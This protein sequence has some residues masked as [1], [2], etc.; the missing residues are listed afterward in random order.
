MQR[1]VRLEFAGNCVLFDQLSNQVGPV[2]QKLERALAIMLAEFLRKIL[3]HDPHAGI[4]QAD[5]APGA[6]KSD[7]GCLQQH[8]IGAALGQ[9]QCGGEAGIPPADNHHVSRVFSLQRR[10]HRCGRRGPL[11]EAVRARIVQHQ[12][13]PFLWFSRLYRGVF[14]V[15]ID[16]ISSGHSLEE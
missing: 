3:R 5:I 2:A 13:F 11:P 10:R 9:M 8:D 12:S 15:N 16:I 7:F 1:A 4:D 14:A 6:A